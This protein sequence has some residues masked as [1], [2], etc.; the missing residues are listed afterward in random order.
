M[1]D[2]DKEDNGKTLVE[3]A[4]NLKIPK[5]VMDFIEFYAEIS[6]I[7]RDVLL[8]NILIDRVRDIKEQFKTLPYMKIPELC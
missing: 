1:E 4:V 7:E 3:E 2:T 5:E 8:T 6:G